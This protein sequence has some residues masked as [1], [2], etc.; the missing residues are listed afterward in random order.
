MELKFAMGVY[1]GTKDNEII[2]EKNRIGT[3]YFYCDSSSLVAYMGS[4]MPVGD[5]TFKRCTSLLLINGENYFIDGTI[6]KNKKQIEEALRADAL[7]R[8][9]IFSKTT[10][11]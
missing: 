7:E 9:S 1:S 6:E 11:N 8:F 4:A 2:T 3:E 10:N 5:G